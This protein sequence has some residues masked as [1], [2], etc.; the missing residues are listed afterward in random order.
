MSS[1]SRVLKIHFML[2]NTIT[3]SSNTGIRNSNAVRQDTISNSSAKKKWEDEKWERDIVVPSFSKKFDAYRISVGVDDGSCVIFKMTK[4]GSRRME[5]RRLTEGHKKAFSEVIKTVH[6]R[7]AI[8]PNPDS[9]A[10]GFSF[11]YSDEH[12]N[13]SAVCIALRGKVMLFYR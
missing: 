5:W 8:S 7:E 11:A 6:D 3:L 10:E 13:F 4:K 9:Y 2:D 1:Q 12:V